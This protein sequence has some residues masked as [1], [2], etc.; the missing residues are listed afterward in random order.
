ME[1]LFFCDPVW[2]R[3][4]FLRNRNRSQT[5]SGLLQTGSGLRTSSHC[6]KR[7][8]RNIFSSDFILVQKRV[9]ITEMHSNFFFECMVVI[10]WLFEWPL[11]KTFFQSKGF[12]S[13][14]H[15]IKKPFA[16][17][18]N[19][20][21]PSSIWYIIWAGESWESWTFATFI[22]VSG[23]FRYPIIFHEHRSGGN[24]EKWLFYYLGTL[25]E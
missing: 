11:V 19:S 2:D 14:G 5:G 18:K 6:K 4:R 8:D 15:L 16:H 25:S 10:L 20:F 23:N 17:Y 12:F 22:R 9:L 13:C 7:S 21:L 3:I 24:W 1:Q